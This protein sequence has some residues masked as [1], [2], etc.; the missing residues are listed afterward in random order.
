[1][2]FF[3]FLKGKKPDIKTTYNNETD[4]ETL[5]QLGMAYIH[6]DGVE[7]DYVKATEILQ[8]A[9][10]QGHQDSKFMLGILYFN[11]GVQQ[12]CSKAVKLFKELAD[13]DDSIA[14]FHLGEAYFYGKGVEQNYAK[15]I[16]IFKELA[17]QGDENAQYQL[18]VIYYTGQGVEQNF[19][20]AAELFEASAF[21]DPFIF[22]RESVVMGNNKAQYSLGVMY[23]NGEGVEQ[24]F[25]KAAEL[26]EASAWRGEN[27]I[28]NILGAT[29]VH[30]GIE[31]DYI[32]TIKIFPEPD[33]QHSRS[34]SNEE[35]VRD[36]VIGMIYCEK[37]LKNG[38]AQARY[39]LGLAFAMGKGVRRNFNSAAELFQK[40]ADQGYPNAQCALG[41][42]YANGQGVEQDYSKAKELFNLACSGGYADGCENY[43][44]LNKN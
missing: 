23:A 38:V 30:G 37:L 43:D 20:K 16:Q 15:A 26:F 29:Y 2:G 7:K 39:C 34:D 41:Y 36:F 17:D 11:D 4:A 5:Y 1:M 13:Q 14:L 25:Y 32:K 19:Y 3:D 12:N 42:L 6:E 8:K 40:A 44:I 31:K 9:V 21:D 33:K 18:G 28:P 10:D 24:N 35:E 22:F 27:S